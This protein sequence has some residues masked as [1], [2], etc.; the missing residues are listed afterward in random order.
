MAEEYQEHKDAI[1]N[2]GIAMG[3]KEVVELSSLLFFRACVFPNHSK[4]G[5]YSQCQ[6][7]DDC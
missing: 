2:C 3:Q 4:A 1:D 7:N 5:C 6:Q